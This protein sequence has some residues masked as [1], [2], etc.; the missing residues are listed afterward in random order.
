[1][2]YTLENL[3][4]ECASKKSRTDLPLKEKKRVLGDVW[5]ALNLWIDSQFEKGKVLLQF[6]TVSP[7]LVF[8]FLY[9]SREFTL[10][11]LAN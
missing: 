10:Q 4:A 3:V 6:V 7:T 5:E 11:T 9:V 1:M 2:V 8:L